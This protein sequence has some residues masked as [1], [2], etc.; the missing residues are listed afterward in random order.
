MEHS[1][2]MKINQCVRITENITSITY[3]SGIACNRSIDLGMVVNYH[4]AVTD[5]SKEKAIRDF[6][7]N[8][9]SQF[10]IAKTS[11]LLSYIPF[12]TNPGD[13]DVNQ[14]FNN[15]MVMNMTSGDQKKKQ[16]FLEGLIMPDRDG[17]RGEGIV[18]VLHQQ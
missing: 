15:S 1:V 12:S 16:Y 4:N 8:I 10:D 6:V 9:A 13:F 3:P 14:W 17:I 7:I 2:H 5:E 11:T 18:L